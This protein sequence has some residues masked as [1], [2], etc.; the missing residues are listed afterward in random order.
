MPKPIRKELIMK[1]SNFLVNIFSLVLVLS[2]ITGCSGTEA[3]TQDPQSVS[4]TASP[5][6]AE[7]P[8]A[9]LTRQ[10][11][12]AQGYQGNAPQTAPPYDWIDPN[13]TPPDGAFY[14]LYETPRR[15][16]RIPRV[17]I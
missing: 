17:V 14:E 12:Q 10:N 13:T 15:V 11:T 8:T 4:Q 16:E 9:G 7:T 6:L 3:I 2:F 1:T 5:T